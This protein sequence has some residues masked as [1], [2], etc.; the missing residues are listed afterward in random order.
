MAEPYPLNPQQ[1]QAVS[2]LAGPDRYRHFVSRVSDWQ[3]VW[4]LKDESGWVSAADDQG[5]LVFPFWPHPDYAAACATG[6][7]TGN[8]PAS[9]E[10]HE[11]LERWLPNMDKDEVEAAVF[12]TPT[13]RGVIIPALQLQRAIQDE[14]SN[15]E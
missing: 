14:L 3:H 13:M 6:D 10:V 12:P 4:S 11:F 2:A 7:W 5:N 15:I 8:I 1:F 9:I